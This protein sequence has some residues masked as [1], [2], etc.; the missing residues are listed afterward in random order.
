M[1]GK[2]WN[3]DHEPERV[4]AA[5]DESLRDLQTDY[6]DLYLIH[7]PVSFR[8]VR[9]KGH[10]VSPETGLIDVIEV[11]DAVTWTKLE[12]MVAKGKVR[13][14]GVSNFTKNRIER[15][16]QRYDNH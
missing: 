11:P 12:E 8:Y 7:W 16:C 4:E 13:S 1:T 14:I 10:P 15:L 6:L 9:E 3:T 5:L 2:L